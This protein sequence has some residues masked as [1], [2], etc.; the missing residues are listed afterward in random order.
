LNWHS[1]V[2]SLKR[3]GLF[4]IYYRM[5]FSA[6]SKL[7]NLLREDL[8]VDA[9]KARNRTSNQ[10]PIGPEM[11][12]HFTLHYLYGNLYL[13]VMI[14]TGISRAAFYSCVY[15]GI[16]AICKCPDLQLKMPTSISEMKVVASGFESLSLDGRLNG[17]IGALDGWLCRIK[18]PSQKETYNVGSYFSG[19]YQSYGVNVQATCDCNS[20]FTSISVLC[21]GGTGDSKAYAASYLHSYVSNLPSGFYLV[22]DNAYTLSDTLLICIRIVQASGL[23]VSK[24]RIFKKPLEVTLFRVSHIVQACAQ[25]HNFI[26][27][28]D[29]SAPL[30]LNHYPESYH[31]NLEEFVPAVQTLVT[32]RSRCCAV[33]EAI[34][35]RLASD[36]VRRPLYNIVWNNSAFV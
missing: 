21:P 9:K 10:D 5:S 7:L 30:I 31:P 12:L 8:R 33:R 35:A 14:H 34:C 6:F 32:A 13:D 28:Q 20:H 26:D 3:H 15:Q 29:D 19:H 36:G 23:L 22:A 25:L 4:Q 17:C 11:I 16:D 1:H 24:W 2:K 27:N 18:V